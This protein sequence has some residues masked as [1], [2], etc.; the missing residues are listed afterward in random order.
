MDEQKLVPSYATSAI[1]K[2]PRSR[3]EWE[4]LRYLEILQGFP[5]GNIGNRVWKDANDHSK[6]FF[7]L[8][9]NGNEMAWFPTPGFENREGC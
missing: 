2:R 6:G 4:A 1:R 8:D 7:E 5:T 9:E 3:T